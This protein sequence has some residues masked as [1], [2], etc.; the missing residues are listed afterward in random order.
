MGED[1]AKYTPELGNRI[2]NIN[3]YKHMITFVL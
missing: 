1:I 2:C 3:K